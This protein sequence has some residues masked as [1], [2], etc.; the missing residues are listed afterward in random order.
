MK[1]TLF[2]RRSDPKEFAVQAKLDDYG[3][4]KC[5]NFIRTEVAGGRDPLPLLAAAKAGQSPWEDEKYLQ[6]ALAD[7]ALLFHDYEG[8]VEVLSG[9]NGCVNAIFAALG[10]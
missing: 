10:L 9:A 7:D 4:I 2:A 3:V 1:I 8:D 5:I 6:P